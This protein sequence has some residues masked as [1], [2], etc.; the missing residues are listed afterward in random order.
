MVASLLIGLLC[1]WLV[2]SLSCAI[3]YLMINNLY[4]VDNSAALAVYR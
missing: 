2:P 3:I 1:E 4:I